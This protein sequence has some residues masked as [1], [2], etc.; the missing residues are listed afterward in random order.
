MSDEAVTRRSRSYDRVQ[1]AYD[2]VQTMS[3][4]EF[5]M[6]QQRV[7]AL[8]AFGNQLLAQGAYTTPDV[9]N[10]PCIDEDEA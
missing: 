8:T 9:A 4:L 5:A 2:L 6:F 3:V 1:T 10:P 7:N